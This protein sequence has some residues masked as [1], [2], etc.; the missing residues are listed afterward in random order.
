MEDFGTVFKKLRESRHLSL[1]DISKMG[2]STSQISRFE[3]GESDL[4]ITKFIAILKKMNI[5]IDEY[6]YVVNNFKRDDLSELLY[7]INKYLINHDAKGL[8]NLLV[9][10][11]EKTDDSIYHRLHIL[12]IKIRLSFLDSYNQY[13]LKDIEELSEYLFS[14]EYWGIYELLIF[15]SVIDVLEPQLYMT[16]LREMNR[17]VDFYKDIP[18]NKKLIIIM[19]INANITC[20]EANDFISADYI[21]KQ[22]IRMN[23]EETDLY[24][25]LFFKYAKNIYNYKVS[26]DE[27]YLEVI[28]KIIAAVKIADSEHLAENFEEHLNKILQLNE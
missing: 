7:Q 23:I 13:E 14:V 25:R 24:E 2:V 9:T 3:N 21:E 28:K 17:R 18:R 20:V 12:I 15:S 10:Y 8:K 1:A 16:L 26:K 27:K 6:L 5:S 4:T 22:I 19:N 11:Q